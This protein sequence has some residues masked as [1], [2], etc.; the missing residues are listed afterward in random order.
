MVL[1][2][3]PRKPHASTSTSSWS[4][5][6]RVPPGRP[7]LSQRGAL[8]C[9]RGRQQRHSRPAIRSKT[10]HAHDKDDA[11]IESFRRFHRLPSSIVTGT[12]VLPSVYGPSAPLV[13]ASVTLNSPIGQRFTAKTDADGGFTFSGLPPATYQIQLSTPVRQLVRKLRPVAGE[14]SFRPAAGHVTLL[15]SDS[16]V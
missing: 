6:L 3:S 13:G 7:L 15:R 12:Y 14:L 10:R 8:P 5:W 11:E 9:L 16:G 2:V 4:L 1:V